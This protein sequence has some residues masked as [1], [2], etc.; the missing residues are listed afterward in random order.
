MPLLKRSSIR[1]DV[2]L[3]SSN[4]Q[5]YAPTRLSVRHD[6]RRDSPSAQIQASMSTMKR[7]L[8]FVGALL[9][10]ITLGTG[11]THHVSAL[12][13][14]K[15]RTEQAQITYGL[16]KKMLLTQRISRILA[17]TNQVTT[18]VG[19]YSSSKDQI[20]LGAD[21]TYDAAS[22][23]KLITAAA[24]L[25]GVDTKS[26]ELS[27][28]LDGEPASFWLNQMITNSDD[29]AWNVLNTYLTH[30]LLTKYA[31]S[32]GLS[33]YYADSNRISAKDIA[34]ML[35]RLQ[36]GTLL[37]KLSSQ[38]LISY[39]TDANY[40]QYI[41]PAVPKDDK[42]YHKVGFDNDTVNDAA[43]MY[44]GGTWVVLVIFTDGNGTYHLEDRAK[45]IQDITQ[46][47]VRTYL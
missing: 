28:Q 15:K 3:P 32:V 21:Q 6:S 37:S 45:L 20:S 5:S 31:V 27:Q 19:I 12:D 13:A 47:V 14:Q 41:L 1:S 2:R 29:Q 38:R 16:Q 42:V 33:S 25:H 44:R 24:Y 9:A 43:V 34:I 30:S 46:V 23:G 17:N 4:Y 18:T 39:M 22:I 11:W 35:N 36:N 40:R 8:Y 26:Q 7:K 10:L